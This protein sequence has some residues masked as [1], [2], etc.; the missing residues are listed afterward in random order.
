MG[1]LTTPPT[2]KRAKEE[3][4]Q[5]PS[6]GRSGLRRVNYPCDS[7]TSHQLKYIENSGES[8]GKCSDFAMFKSPDVVRAFSSLAGTYLS[9]EPYPLLA[10]DT[11]SRYER[12]RHES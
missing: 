5:L 4:E 6:K 11:P 3:L 10:F 12:I 7:A 2:K 1:A 8:N 9:P